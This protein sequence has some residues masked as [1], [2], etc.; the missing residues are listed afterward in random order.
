KLVR[1]TSDEF[2]FKH[3]NEFLKQPPDLAFIDGMHLFEYA[4]RDFINIE[5]HSSSNTLVVIDDIYPNHPAQ[6]ERDRRTRAW[7]GDVWKLHAILTD[8]RPDLV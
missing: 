8:Y 4:L 5:R 3:A 6:A 7:T 1:S 2:F